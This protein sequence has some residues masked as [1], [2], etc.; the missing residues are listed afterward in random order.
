MIAGLLTG[1][2]DRAVAGADEIVKAFGDRFNYF[3][4]IALLAWD[5]VKAVFAGI[6]EWFKSKVISPVTA[7]FHG[8]INN[9]TDMVEG[10]VNFFI[11]GVNGIIRALNS[12]SV[13]IPE[14]VPGIGGS[15]FGINIQKVP[16][17]KLPRLAQGA[18]IPPN[19][20]FLAVLGDQKSGTNIETPLPTMIQ[21]FKQAFREVGGTGGGDTTIIMEVDGQQFA[22]LVYKANKSESRRVGVRLVEV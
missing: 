5:S 11:R 10:F 21:A 7:G 22:K 20:E 12:I 18:V 8:F 1:D 3:R 2:F 14:W 9:L 17:L 4:D 19:R 13:D 16:E 6:A 15:S